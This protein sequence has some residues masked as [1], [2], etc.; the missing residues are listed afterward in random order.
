MAR[1][2]GY[3][4]DGNPTQRTINRLCAA[5]RSQWSEATE[6]SRRVVVAADEL[7]LFAQLAPEPLTEADLE[8]DCPSD[9]AIGYPWR[10]ASISVLD[11][12]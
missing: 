2:A 1:T 9:T 10:T 4:K 7:P 11:D 8:L 12:V 6:R 5:I 3:R